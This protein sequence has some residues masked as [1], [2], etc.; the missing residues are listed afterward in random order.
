MERPFKIYPPVIERI[1]QWPIYK[2]S[3]RREAFLK[4]I[5]EFTLNR[6][7]QTHPKLQDLIAE[8][9]YA[10]RIRIREDPWKVDPPNEK[11]FWNRIRRKIVNLDADKIKEHEELHEML[12]RI[13]HRYS[14]EIVGTFSI[15]TFRFARRF[16]TIFFNRLLNTAAGRNWRRIFSSKFQLYDRIH[17]MG[18]VDAIRSLATKGTVIVAPTHFSN[19]DSILVGYAMDSVM[20]LPSFSYGA[21][22]NLYN[23]GLVAFFFNRLGAYRVDRRKKNPIYQE[24]LRSMSNLSIQRGT[25][26]LFFPGGTRSRS[27]MIETKLKLGLLSTVVEAQRAICQRVENKSRKKTEH[28]IP[29]T[30]SIKN[31]VNNDAPI[32]KRNNKIF[33]VPLVLGYH[34][35]LEA[36]FLIEQYLRETGK[37]QYL[38]GKDEGS[39]KR[40][41]LRFIWKIFSQKSDIILSF[42]KPMDVLGNFVDMDGVSYDKNGQ[43]INIE[44]YFTSNGVVNQ[45]LQREG[46]YTKALAEKIVDRFYKENIVLSSHIVAFVAFNMLKAYNDKMDLYSVL[47]L[48]CDDFIFPEKEFTAAIAALQTVLLNLEVKD[49]LKLSEA[50]KLS[51]DELLKDGLKNLGVFHVQKPLYLNQEGD[52]ESQDFPT[53]YYYH[54]RL[55]NYG[56][57]KRVDW[58]KYKVTVKRE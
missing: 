47:R 54:N 29:V 22:L 23:S 38:K 2:L 56:L 43:K 5:D 1:E 12:G 20:G 40:K 48:P 13:I 25:N 33:V 49:K 51:P 26:S 7:A 32:D 4:E 39:S 30:S 35:V 10:E 45:D 28:E 55:E 21:G 18:E 46:E 44:D 11:Q 41:W 24:T 3:R 34:F 37:A 6:L 58:E 14:Q 8:T 42:G 15:V 57:T 19:L 17:V 16:L 52:V 36:P 50:A 9:M 27:G 53:L 31:D